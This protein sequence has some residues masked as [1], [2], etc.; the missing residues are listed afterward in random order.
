MI[1]FPTPTRI[2]TN[3]ITLS[4]HQA[5]PKDGL[6][7]LLLH[8][9][10]ELARSWLN[11][12]GPLA[13][14]GFRVIAPDMRGFGA[15]DAPKDPSLYGIDTLL[16]DMTGLLDALGIKKAVWVGHDWGGLIIW[17]AALLVPDHV[18]GVIGVNTPHLPRPPVCPMEMLRQRYGDDHYFVRFQELGAPE[19]ALEGREEDFFKFVFARPP[20]HIPKT[21]PPSA[22]H[23]LNRFADFTDRAERNI[24]VP[25]AERTHYAR[26]Y[27]KSGFHGGVNYYRNVTANWERMEGVDMTVHQ[28][29]LMISAELD[30]FLPP[31]FMDGMEERVPDLQKHVI[32]GC[33]H[34][35]QWEKPEELSALMV[36]WLLKHEKNLRSQ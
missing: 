36:D 5:G 28:P 13:K 24:V 29:S 22:T 16:A 17:P 31:V 12:I 9:W 6:P 20:K 18:A 11:Q 33:G 32:M 15:S 34:W 21:L 4:V 10:P 19:A 14:A 23:L 27:A 30:P 7:V 25:A 26:A 1:D 35:T 8:G 2:Q 3:G